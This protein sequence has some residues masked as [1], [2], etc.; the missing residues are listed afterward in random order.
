MSDSDLDL[1]DLSE[2]IRLMMRLIAD[3]SLRVETCRLLLRAHGS[4]NEEYEI[5]QAE[6]KR[7]WDAETDALVKRIGDRRTAERLRRLL[8]S[9]EKPKH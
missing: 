7:R 3:L 1:E 6:L 2:S 8:E 4:T 5:A 9:T